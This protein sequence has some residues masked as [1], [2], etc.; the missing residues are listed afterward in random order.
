V[1]NLKREGKD[2]F[3][4][5]LIRHAPLPSTLNP[6]LL[7]SPLK[8][9]R[10]KYFSVKK[11]GGLF[12]P[13][14]PPPSYAHEPRPPLYKSEIQHNRWNLHLKTNLSPVAQTDILCDDAAVCG[15]SPSPAV[16]RDAVLQPV[17]PV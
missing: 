6:I 2:W 11:F 14:F 17:C 5:A 9:S 10:K 8:L 1:V 4:P 3:E 12:A 15:V 13:F 7:F 16:H